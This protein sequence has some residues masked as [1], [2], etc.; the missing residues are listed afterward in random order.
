[1]GFPGK[2]TGMDCH[3]LLHGI[4]PT[5][6]WNPHLLCPLHW[7]VGSLPLAPPNSPLYSPRQAQCLAQSRPWVYVFPGRSSSSSTK[8]ISLCLCYPAVLD[9]LQSHGSSP[10]IITL[11]RPESIGIH[12][13]KRYKNWKLYL[14]FDAK[15]HLATMAVPLPDVS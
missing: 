12:N 9:H 2:N 4:F 6:R 13:S 10:Q 15:T 11:R 1:M 14:K 5:Q 3:A 8:V 7:R